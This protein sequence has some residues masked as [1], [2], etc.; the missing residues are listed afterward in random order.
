MQAASKTEP[1]SAASA[2]PFIAAGLAS[3]IALRSLE[4]VAELQRAMIKFPAGVPSRAMR[5]HG[6]LSFAERCP[7]A[8]INAMVTNIEE[9][10]PSFSSRVPDAVQSDRV[11]LVPPVSSCVACGST[12]LS[13]A[14]RGHRQ[15]RMGEPTH[16]TVYS[17]R[18]VLRGE[19]Y[20]KTCTVCGAAHT[21]SFAEG[22]ERIEKGK[23]LP[24]A[25]ATSREREYYQMTS[26]SV[27]ETSLLYRFET[28]ALH[29]HTG[30]QTFAEEY[31][32]LT[33]A[34][35]LTDHFRRTLA[36]A[37]LSWSLL[38]WRSERREDSCI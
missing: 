27:F 20:I 14:R 17:E 32:D 23:V 34:D 37:W 3:V 30:W 28:Q 19:L 21:L 22:G 11:M 33:G 5:I 31:R 4:E 7:V 18:G 29:S 1:P 24:Y 13:D 8:E 2:P 16:P 9:Q 26:G 35:E 25:D 36:H 10:W 15:Y 38:R 6:V 12:E